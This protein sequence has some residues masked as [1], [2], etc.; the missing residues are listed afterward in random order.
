MA[1]SLKERMHAQEAVMPNNL[2]DS[3]ICNMISSAYHI[4]LLVYNAT[5]GLIANASPNTTNDEWNFIETGCKEQL[6][7]LCR[8]SKAPQVL[9]S[10]VNQVWLGI[11][12]VVEDCLIK[13][14]V[15]GPVFT[16]EISENV[17]VEYA[18]SKY[19]TTSAKDRL[20]EVYQTTP[21]LPYIELV[22]LAMMIYYY[23]Y[24]EEMDFSWLAA[25]VDVSDFNREAQMH[26]RND[27]YEERDFH[28]TYAFE[29]YIWECIREGNA[30][31]LKRHLHVGTHG[32]IGPIGNR[33]P[34]RQQKNVFICAVTL[35]TRAAVE[36]GLSSEVAYSLSDF[37][38][39]QVETMNNVL[40]V[41]A[42]SEAML[43]DFA[44]R[45][46][47]KKHPQPYSKLIKS[48]CDYIDEHARENVH[49]SDVA[50]HVGLSPDYVSKSF[51][52]ETGI[53]ISDY[54]KKAKISEAKSLLRY[55]ELSLAEISELLSF[56]SQS[57]FSTIFKQQIGI[58]PRQFREKNDT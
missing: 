13:L 37:Y 54:L 16:S 31:R 29:Q 5:G 2:E 11:P 47:R 55:S 39:Q 18:R 38:I 53:S 51:R 30:A 10:D 6:F 27:L 57:F 58:T 52:A 25:S 43:Y 40:P 32:K 14:F 17:I 45:V 36:G 8:S 1:E 4:T 12:V 34:V 49:V 20:L 23:I 56:S 19:M 15:L 22:K 24:Q 28:A 3:L 33:S 26:D 21:V 7:Q 50:A 46:G 48:C 42:L 9:S 41:L 35:A 44:E